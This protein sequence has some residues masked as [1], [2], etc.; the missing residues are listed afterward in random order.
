MALCEVVAA[1]AGAITASRQ[2][3]TP[4]EALVVHLLQAMPLY[5][6]L[7]RLDLW[8]QAVNQV[9]PLEESSETERLLSDIYSLGWQNLYQAFQAARTQDFYRSFV[10]RFAEAGIDLPRD[11]DLSGW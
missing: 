3:L 2:P 5:R 9:A 7:R 1:A 6:D 10:E 4:K 8:E 11:P